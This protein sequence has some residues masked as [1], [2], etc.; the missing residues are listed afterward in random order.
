LKIEQLLYLQIFNF[1]RKIESNLG[2]FLQWHFC[3]IGELHPTVGRHLPPDTGDLR[4]AFSRARDRQQLL[5][6]RQ[7]V[8]RV[9]IT[10][11]DHLYKAERRHRRVILFFLCFFIIV[12]VL[13]AAGVHHRHRFASIRS[14]LPCCSQHRCA[15]FAPLRV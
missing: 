5:H 12:V 4:S 7:F 11:L 6:A 8:S 15:S 13:S 1:Y 10:L 3:N 14:I 2:I 9:A